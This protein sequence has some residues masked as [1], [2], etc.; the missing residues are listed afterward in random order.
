MFY[1]LTFIASIPAWF[2]LAPVQE[3]AA[4]AAVPVA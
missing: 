3:G 4:V 2:L 1:L